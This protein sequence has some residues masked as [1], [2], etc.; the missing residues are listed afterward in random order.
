MQRVQ[1]KN[2]KSCKTESLTYKV[3]V[4]RIT[5]DISAEILKARRPWN[6]ILHPLS[7][8]ICQPRLLKPAKYPLKLLGKKPSKVKTKAIHDH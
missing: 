5:S 2:I 4:I 1:S 6:D 3:E 8:N 7:I